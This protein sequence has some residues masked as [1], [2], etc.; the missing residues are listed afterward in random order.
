MISNIREVYQCKT[1]TKKNY[2]ID[3]FTNDMILLLPKSPKSF[4]HLL[5]MALSNAFKFTESEI[6]ASINTIAQVVTED[7]LNKYLENVKPTPVIALSKRPEIKPEVLDILEH[8][9]V[10]IAMILTRHLFGDLS[11]TN[12]DQRKQSEA[13]LISRQGNYIT[14]FSYN[15]HSIV[16]ETQLPDCGTTILLV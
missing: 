11:E 15:N 8:N 12:S 9:E 2:I 14:R 13:T 1:V 5:T 10:R 7:A 6:H 4:V 3:D 16:V